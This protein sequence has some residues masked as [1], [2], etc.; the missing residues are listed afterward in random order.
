MTG[1][2]YDADDFPPWPARAVD[3]EP[4][5]HDGRGR[6]DTPE[7]C[8]TRR[9]QRNWWTVLPIGCRES[10]AR[11]QPQAQCFH[12]AGTDR[13]VLSLMPFGHRRVGDEVEGRR[14]DAEWQ[15]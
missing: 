13:S 8:Q 7:P 12:I 11:E 9:D 2:R 4:T 3:A 6:I 14:L 5:P 10:A 1:I 15:S